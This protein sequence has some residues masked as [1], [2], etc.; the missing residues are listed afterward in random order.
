MQRKQKLWLVD[1]A[2]QGVA[3]GYVSMGTEGGI[4]TESVVMELEQ[5]VQ[6]REFE[7]V[8]APGTRTKQEGS[9]ENSNILLFRTITTT[10]AKNYFAWH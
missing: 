5:V 6:F 2:A 10:T 3:Y 7:N 8:D 9:T 1:V 4:E